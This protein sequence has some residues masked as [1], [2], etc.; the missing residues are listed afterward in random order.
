MGKTYTVEAIAQHFNRPLISLTVANIGTM[1]TT[2]EQKLIR[3]FSLAEAWN[4]VLLVD[5]ADIFLER[6]QNRD[7][8]RN[9]L[10]SGTKHSSLFTP[11]DRFVPLS[12]LAIIS[13]RASCAAHLANHALTAF[14]RRMEY[15]QGLLFLTT[16][17]VGQVDD[18]FISRVHVAIGYEALNPD[19][20]SKIW[21][22]F[23][24][25]L[26]REMAEKI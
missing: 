4:A 23:F 17:R 3:W 13:A 6:R 21:Q 8:S 7:L 15:F 9:D 11:I 16:N 19:T 25:K 26:A 2:V 10:V 18:A 22:G 24:A 12:W 20:R 5:E 1:E 14:L